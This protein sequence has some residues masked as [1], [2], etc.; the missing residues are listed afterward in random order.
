MFDFFKRKKYLEALVTQ[1]MC[2]GMKSNMNFIPFVKNDSQNAPGIHVFTLGLA[3]GENN[4]AASRSELRGAESSRGESS[5][6]HI[7]VLQ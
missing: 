5:P 1:V 3:G 2:H 6:T 4:F 7:A